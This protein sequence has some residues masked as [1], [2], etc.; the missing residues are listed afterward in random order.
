MKADDMRLFHSIQ[1]IPTKMEFAFE[2]RR[3]N[4]EFATR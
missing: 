4:A 3:Q 1:V 2:T